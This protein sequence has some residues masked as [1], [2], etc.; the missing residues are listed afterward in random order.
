MD[1][2]DNVLSESVDRLSEELELELEL[3]ELL[4]DRLDV[5]LSAAVLAEERLEVDRST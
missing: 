4:V 1:P 5:L 3:S 2:E